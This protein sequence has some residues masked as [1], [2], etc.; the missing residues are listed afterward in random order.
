MFAGRPVLSR[1]QICLSED[2][3]RFSVTY[4]LQRYPVGAVKGFQLPGTVE[5]NIAFHRS[6]SATRTL[7]AHEHSMQRCFCTMEEIAAGQTT[8]LRASC[9]H[10][11]ATNAA[12][13]S[14][15]AYELVP[16]A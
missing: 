15:E 14:G 12:Q 11:H 10:P 6:R 16:G 2:G 8:L 13:F 1:G 5:A 9:Q 4:P 3:R 7:A